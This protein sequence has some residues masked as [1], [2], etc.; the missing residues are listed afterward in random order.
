MFLLVLALLVYR[1]R[2][3][4]EKGR[5]GAGGC[6]DRG[7]RRQERRVE[8]SK[9]AL[10]FSREGKNDFASKKKKCSSCRGPTRTL[11]CSRRKRGKKWTR[12]EYLFIVSP[13][14]VC[15]RPLDLSTQTFVNCNGREHFIS[16]NGS[17]RHR[18]SETSARII[19]AHGAKAYA[20]RVV[21]FPCHDLSV[22]KPTVCV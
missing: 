2:Y 10:R 9:T 17:R 12:G 4:R 16:N 1:V 7:G 19:C 5:A 8:R 18:T 11:D 6:R 15:P 14:S 3:Q 20:E 21:R 22:W 13:P